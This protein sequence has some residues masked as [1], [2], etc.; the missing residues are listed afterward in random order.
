[1]QEQ[2][3][4]PNNSLTIALETHPGQ[5]QDANLWLTYGDSLLMA[6]FDGMGGRSGLIGEEQGARVASQSA[7]QSA[8]NFFKE[9]EKKGQK[10]DKTNF[11][12]LQQHIQYDLRRI[13]NDADKNAGRKS[14]VK[15]FKDTLQKDKLAT[16][17]ALVSIF[18]SQDSEDI[19]DLDLAWMGDSRIYF[20]SPHKGLQQLTK[21]DLE[22]YKDA[23]DS[24]LEAGSPMS[25]YLTPNTSTDGA[26]NFKRV[27]IEEEGLVIA[28]TD[29]AFDGLYPWQFEFVLL[30]FL[31]ISNNIKEWKDKLI[32]YNQDREVGDD[33][34]L[35]LFIIGFSNNFNTLK[36]SYKNRYQQISKLC[37]SNDSKTPEKLSQIWNIYRKN[38][39]EKIGEV[40]CRPLANSLEPVINPIV[41][42][43]L[44]NFKSGSAKNLQ[45]SSEEINKFKDSIDIDADLNTNPL[46]NL[47][48]SSI[49]ESFNPK[50]TNPDF[51]HPASEN[52]NKNETQQ[53]LNANY[54]GGR[55]KE[56]INPQPQ[57]QSNISTCEQL[58]NPQDTE[59]KQASSPT[60]GIKTTENENLQTKIQTVFLLRIQDL[61]NQERYDEAMLELERLIGGIDAPYIPALSYYMLAS[62]KRR[63]KG[64]QLPFIRNQSSKKSDEES[65]TTF[66]E[67]CTLI[68]E[69]KFLDDE[70]EY[71]YFSLEKLAE[72]LSQLEISDFYII[73]LTQADIELIKKI[74]LKLNESKPE[75]SKKNPYLLEL[76]GKILEFERKKNEQSLTE[77][78]SK[79]KVEDVKWY[80]EEACGLYKQLGNKKRVDEC[81]KQLNELRP[82]WERDLLMYIYGL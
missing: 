41:A 75:Q 4:Q 31:K 32:Q 17:L 21:D 78:E 77:E 33:V 73:N 35:L 79:K 50:Q 76:Q 58:P 81:Q 60:S 55:S 48:D 69:K 23:F 40:Q 3:E 68:Q 39:E 12:G 54:D 7:R 1:M 27:Q 72:S 45:S 37:D 25:Q 42:Q 30:H 70:T 62:L 44:S 67:I 20:L 10:L 63:N 74:C 11:I 13:K 18:Q 6:V 19:I 29:G 56:L 46:P 34:T 59:V 80:F 26:I 65:S 36:A 82:L 15:G 2:I 14:R 49:Q 57:D 28:C 52:F 43:K 53:A 71:T 64:I 9:L 51:S 38:Y 22:E 24:V 8:L 61:L 16:T 66:R 47:N 5:G